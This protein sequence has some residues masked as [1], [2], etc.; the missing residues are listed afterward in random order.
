MKDPQDYAQGYL[1]KTVAYR[2]GISV[3]IHDKLQLFLVESPFSIDDNITF[4][5]RSKAYDFPSM[6]IYKLA[7]TAGINAD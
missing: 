3:P 5:P 1:L 6:S 4:N 7:D 2:C